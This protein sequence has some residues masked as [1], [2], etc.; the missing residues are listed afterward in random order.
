M[1]LYQ[2]IITTLFA[3]LCCLALEH[4][5]VHGHHVLTSVDVKA[6]ANVNIPFKVRCRGDHLCDT[7]REEIPGR[8][9]QAAV[10]ALEAEAER[11][12]TEASTAAVA[13]RDH[14]IYARGYQDGYMAADEKKSDAPSLFLR[15]CTQTFH[16]ARLNFYR[17]RTLPRH[18]PSLLEPRV[19]CC[20]AWHLHENNWV[21]R[22]SPGRVEAG[23]EEGAGRKGCDICFS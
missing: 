3:A 20:A 4:C 18:H 10:D 14:Q 6:A 8:Q 23:G 1:M 12:K 9:R 15:C 13:A 2:C 22:R 19:L 11:E 17:F 21:S 5:S 7:H 16:S